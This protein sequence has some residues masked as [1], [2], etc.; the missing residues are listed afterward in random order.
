MQL[1]N[2]SIRHRNSEPSH[3][4]P[5]WAIVE[6][7]AGQPIGSFRNTGGVVSLIQKVNWKETLQRSFDH[8]WGEVYT[9]TYYEAWWVV[10]NG[11]TPSNDDAVPDTFGRKI[12]H[13]APRGTIEIDATAQYHDNVEETELPADMK[14]FNQDTNA[15][16]LR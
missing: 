4:P 13:D 3:R 5:N 15:G 14:R 12:P 6:N 8:P 9:K 7:C 11:K 2:F 1:R 10:E 16:S